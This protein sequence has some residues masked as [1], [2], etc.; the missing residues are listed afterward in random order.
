AERN[1]MAIRCGQKLHARYADQVE[2][3]ISVAWH[4]IPYSEGGWAEWDA[5]QR[6]TDYATLLEPDG[7]IHFAGEHLSYLTG[8]QEGAIL[9]AHDAVAAIGRRVQGANG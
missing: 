3:G 5:E 1:A 6:R 8:W 2:R 4:K 9:S 7:P